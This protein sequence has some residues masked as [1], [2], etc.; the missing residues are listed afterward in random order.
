M[1]E[2]S[3][4][5]VRKMFY[6]MVKEYE[7]D[8]ECARSIGISKSHLS[9]LLASKARPGKKVLDWMGLR[10]EVIYVDNYPGK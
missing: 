7:N 10:S 1:R 9:R 8:S 3:L 5:E 4:W 2:H 6:S